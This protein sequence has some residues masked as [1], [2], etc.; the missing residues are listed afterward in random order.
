M[1]GIG[2]TY[3]ALGRMVE[4]NRSG[5]YTQF[6]YSPTG[7]KMTIFN[8]QTVTKNFVPLAGGGMAVWTSIGLTDIRHPDWLGS[9]RFASTPSRTMYFDTA[10]AP[11]GEPYAQSGTTDLSFTGQNSDTTSGDY[12]FLYRPY[13]TQGRWPSPD[14]AGLA[15]VDSTNPQSW[16]RYAYVLNNPLS[17]VD[18]TGLFGGPRYVPAPTTC[19]PIC[20]FGD[21]ALGNDIFDAVTGTPGT[22]LSLNMY[23]QMSF[24]FSEQ[25][26]AETWNFI[27]QATL[28]LGN[29]SISS[30]PSTT[31]YQVLI[32]NFGTGDQTSGF[33]P[34]LISAMQEG[35]QAAGPAPEVPEDI[36]RAKAFFGEQYGLQIS[37]GAEEPLGA[38]LQDMYMF[39]PD[40]E[41][42]KQ[43]FDQWYANYALYPQ[44]VFQN[45]PGVIQ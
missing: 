21:I 26:W 38:A 34:D 40:V 15:A 35:L 43:Q 37:I 8:G 45:Y 7:F 29:L 20:G 22:Y 12:D 1:D 41:T 4:Q 28:T 10:Y 18:R 33:I 16:N 17:K 14:P 3:D 25:L 23:G 31:G 13:S 44:A 5:S 2:L 32:Q 24:G 9:S 6:M 42:F 39:F 27:D 19:P 36:F 11:F 30:T